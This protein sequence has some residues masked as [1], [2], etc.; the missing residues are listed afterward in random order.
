ML[1][2]SE[3]FIR[4]TEKL[5]KNTDTKNEG[6]CCEKPDSVFLFLELWNSFSGRMWNFDLENPSNNDFPALLVPLALK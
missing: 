3:Y 2:L 5:S 4:A 6:H 1:P